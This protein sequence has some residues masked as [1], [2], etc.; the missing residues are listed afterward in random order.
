MVALEDIVIIYHGK[1]RDGISAAYAA[2]KKFGD[3]AT[4][5]PVQTQQEPPAGLE[6]KTLYILDYS[7]PKHTLDALA[8]RNR[9]VIVID[10]HLSARD[11][12][13]AFPQNVFDMKHSG[14]M[15][16]WAY[17]H[18]ETPAPRIFAYIE[19]HDL[20]KHEL[21][22][23][24]E[25]AAA[26]GQYDLTL[27]DWDRLVRD[28]ESE[29]GFGALIEHGAVLRAYIDRHVE[30][31]ASY[32]EPV[33]FE[34]HTVYAVNCARPYRSAVGNLLAE[35][36]PPFAI[37]WYRYGGAFH[38]SLRSIGDCNVAEIAE[39]YGGGGHRNAASIRAATFADLPFSF[40]S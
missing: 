36:H 4:Y 18:P 14:A 29:E 20:W 9:S 32:A 34:E 12:V 5:I 2:W 25:V 1:C 11:A 19:E 23:T 16:A 39:R 13:T 17:F 30:E 28:T 6:G 35:R 3:R 40:L 21:P 27:A 31:L 15:L 7:Y 38:L 26:I 22:H 33:R 8:A 37:V 10:H 24:G